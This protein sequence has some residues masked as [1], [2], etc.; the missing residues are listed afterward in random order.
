MKKVTIHHRFFIRSITNA[1]D[2]AKQYFTIISGDED[3]PALSIHKFVLSSNLVLYGKYMKI[4]KHYKGQCLFEQTFGVKLDT[5]N[6]AAL[7]LN[8]LN[9]QQ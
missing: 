1:G 7:I 9:K 5:L 4:V 8:N 6:Q 3:E 2:K